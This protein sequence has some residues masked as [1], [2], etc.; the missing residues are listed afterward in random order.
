MEKV[1]QTQRQIISQVF[2]I[3]DVTT[4]PQVW[5]LY[6]KYYLKA[7]INDV[8]KNMHYRGGS[9]FLWS[10]LFIV[11]LIFQALKIPLEDG[12]RVD[13]DS[14]H[15]FLSKSFYGSLCSS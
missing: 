8:L 15:Q 2:N 4:V 10:V 5:T 9:R 3:T 14:R 6:S 1:V 13:D 11:M 7:L 12:M